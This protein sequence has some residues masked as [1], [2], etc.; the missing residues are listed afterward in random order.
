M[1]KLISLFF[2]LGSLAFGQTAEVAPLPASS[3]QVEA[4][5]KPLEP[6]TLRQLNFFPET[7]AVLDPSFLLNFQLMMAAGIT[8]D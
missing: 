6:T 4:F 8:A 3:E 7:P 2:V 5:M 1:K